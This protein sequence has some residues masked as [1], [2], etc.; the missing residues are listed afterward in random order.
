MKMQAGVFTFCD[1]YARPRA[2]PDGSLTYS[3]GN[4][5]LDTLQKRYFHVMQIESEARPGMVPHLRPFLCKIILWRDS[6]ES[7]IQYV[8]SIGMNK[9]R[10]YPE[11]DKLAKEIARQAF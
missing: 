9:Y 4:N 5:D 1:L 11:I 3:D 10:M 2:R 8:R 7:F 6:A